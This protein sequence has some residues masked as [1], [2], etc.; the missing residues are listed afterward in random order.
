ME[1]KPSKK[2]AAKSRKDYMFFGILLVGIAFIITGI[3]RGEV[4]TVLSKAI[5]ICLE[6]IG[7]G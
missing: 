7:I 3:Y 5:T 1:N 4:D 2:A 6:C